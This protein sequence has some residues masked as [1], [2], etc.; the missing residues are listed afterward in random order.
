MNQ[1]RKYS[2]IRIINEAGTDSLKVNMLKIS[3]AEAA[4]LISQGERRKAKEHDGHDA[5]LIGLA[6]MM[7]QND[8]VIRKTKEYLNIFCNHEDF[9]KSKTMRKITMQ[10]GIPIELFIQIIDLGL[11]DFDEAVS[12]FPSLKDYSE[13]HVR[14]LIDE[15]KIGN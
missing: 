2:E 5:N 3:M 12:L 13:E 11:R 10:H 15:M 7:N 9:Q 8:E 4:H 1:K 14:K 6:P